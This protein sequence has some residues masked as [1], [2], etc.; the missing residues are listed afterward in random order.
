MAK[1]Q[2]TFLGLV[3]GVLRRLGKSQ[4]A[5]ATTLST[6]SADTWGGIVRDTVNEGIQEI[7]KEHD[8]STL[9][10][11]ATLS[12]VS[13]RTFNLSTSQSDFSRPISLVD[14]TNG[15]VLQPVGFLDIE[16][17]DPELDDSGSPDAYNIA[18]PNLL[19]N[20]TPSSITYRLRYVARPATLSANADT[21]DLPEFCD[22]P[23]IL[24]TV[25]QLG[26]TREDAQ[27]GG[28]S[29]RQI[30]DTSLA[31]AIGQDRRRMDRAWI[32]QPVFPT[33]PE[34]VPFPPQYDRYR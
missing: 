30:Y 14:T 8:W 15:K 20:L 23:T 2:T 19:F 32:L 33:F 12:S 11:T 18:Y 29:L 28:E 21:S 4:V 22:L 17:D 9:I 10:T 16:Y 3:N 7:H 25:W 1:G 27:D 6:L 13:V 5:S 31:R 34:I 24:W 26:A